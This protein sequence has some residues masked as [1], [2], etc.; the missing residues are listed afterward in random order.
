MVNFT[1][2]C[3][4]GRHQ[5]APV[6]A[7]MVKS[8]HHNLF[9]SSWVQLAHLI[10]KY[11]PPMTSV[12]RRQPGFATLEKICSGGTSDDVFISYTLYLLV[13]WS[14]GRQITIHF[15]PSLQ[16]PNQN[17]PARREGMTLSHQVCKNQSPMNTIH[18]CGNIYPFLWR[19]NGGVSGSELQTESDR[20][21]LV[22]N[23][24]LPYTHVTIVEES[25]TVEYPGQYFD[26][27]ILC[28]FWKKASHGDN[29]CVYK[30][31]K[32]ACLAGSL[33]EGN[34]LS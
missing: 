26:R 23:T 9:W 1:G 15:G 31:V 5:L 14:L 8:V 17:F 16:P 22:D 13:D 25:T 33:K 20:K 27:K 21:F 32:I 28:R 3:T 18:L 6:L 7:K 30:P 11:H 34:A 24:R 29:G 4:T 2:R 19:D 12:M 10:Q